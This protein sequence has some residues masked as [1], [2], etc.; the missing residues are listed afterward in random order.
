MAWPQPTDYNAAIQNLRSSVSD[1]ELRD[2]RPAL[3]ALGLPSPYAGNFA[4]VYKVHCPATG[5]TW[6]VKCFTRESP[7]LRDR[8]R[9]ISKRL[10]Q[11]RLPF[12]VDFEFVEPGFHINGASYP[13][14]KM[15]W[16]EGLALN[17]FV[18]ESLEKPKTLGHLLQLWVKLV[19]RLRKARIAH[20]DLQHGNV[21]LVPAGKGGQ[22]ALKLIDYDGMYVPALAGRRTGELGHPSYQHPQRL[23]EG[24]Y[25]AE[26]DRFS[27]LAIYS[28][29]QGLVVG[30][31]SLWKTFNNDENLLFRDTDF[32]RPAESAVFQELW[33]LSDERARTLAGRLILATQMPLDR[34]PW[35]DEVVRNGTVAPLGPQERQKV[36]GLLGNGRAASAGAARP[37]AS[38]STV[39][40]VSKP[41]PK[42]DVVPRPPDWWRRRPAEI[43]SAIAERTGLSERR[44]LGI[45][46]VAAALLILMLGLGTWLLSPSQP[47]RL[48]AQPAVYV[49]EISP[50][51]ARLGVSRSG[52]SVSGRGGRRTIT[53][54]W[55]NGES[56]IVIRGTKTDYQRFEQRLRPRPGVTE[57]LSIH[58]K[59]LAR[60]LKGHSTPVTSVAFSPDGQRIASGSDDE[61]INLWDAETGQ[62][63]RTMGGHPHYALSHC[64]CSVA[65]SPDG[66]QIASGSG[67]TIKFWDTETGQVM[68]TLNAQA[69]GEHVAFS[70]DGQ[71]IVSGSS[72]GKIRLWDA[73]TGRE[74]RTLDRFGL[75]GS[76]ALSPDGRR[77]ATGESYGMGV[78]I[79]DAETGREI[80][81]LR[82][83][84]RRVSSVAF[85]L[86]GSRIA[87]GSGDKTIKLWNAETGQL[88]RTLSGH[89]NWV[90][91]V[92][93]SPNG[94]RIASVSEDNTIR[95]WNV[96]TGQVIRTMG[97]HPADASTHWV[98]S[99]AFS[100]DGRQIAGGLGD[101]TIKIWDLE[102]SELLEETPTA[103]ETPQPSGPSPAHFLVKVSPPEATIE[104]SGDG[105]TVSGQGETRTITVEQPDGKSEIVIRATLAG[106]GPFE[107]RLWP[108]P[109]IR[110]DIP[111]RLELLPAVFHLQI[112][113]PEASLEVTGDRAT[114]AGQHEA[115]APMFGQGVGATN[116]PGAQ[117]EVGGG[118]VTVS[119]QGGTRTI[120]VDRPDGKSEIVIRVTMPDHQP[121]EKRLRTR[122]GVTEQLTI[123]LKPLV[124]TLSG[125]TSPVS[126]VAFSPDGRR[127]A[128]GSSDETI[129][130]WDAKTGRVIRTLSAHTESWV[131]SVAFSP[132]GQRIVSGSVD[133]TI[134]V[135]DAETGQLVRT[136]SGHSNGVNSVAFSPDGRQIASGSDD[137]TVK[138][139][140]AK[141]GGLV[142]GL[143]GH[144]KGVY[145][146]AFSPDG[147][148]IASGSDDETIKIW[149]AKTGRLVRTL[150]PH[151]SWVSSVAFSP[152]GQRIASGS[153][154]ETIKVW[155]TETGRLVRT[156]REPFSNVFSRQISSVAFSPDGRWIASGS[157]DCTI[158]V[159]DA[160]TGRLIR[161]LSGHTS[162]VSSVAFSPDGE[163]I[164][165]GSGDKTV[166]VWDLG[167]GP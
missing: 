139:W 109:G 7:A 40:D 55:A 66:R 117:L 129:K 155:N 147:R 162:Y 27:H 116:R 163:R 120:T 102:V 143:R 29:V 17:Q 42:A 167:T 69:D 114:A 164:A 105:A 159:W 34:V 31:P 59:R 145:S 134:K 115:R 104:V 26:V 22:L 153:S 136:L 54:H 45:G 75:L 76:V 63:I 81:T 146:V 161:T 128:S 50:P 2:G 23:R 90:T 101:G 64:V 87:S 130:V 48:P 113:P 156:L 72:G 12:M 86:D 92:A 16:V 93:F 140:N 49:V 68:R 97:G 119:G 124:M 13:F 19:G 154:A 100:P 98:Y 39:P 79:W 106:Y 6:A 3:N 141:T 151:K 160:E 9:A 60:T 150:G 51:D 95:L 43:L 91:S 158:K 71:R 36:D 21:L 137:K 152:D 144:T 14:L 52:V 15:R 166:K 65:F 56:E 83:H 132:D 96:E 122:P 125:H 28:A 24:I 30:G 67:S 74:L 11:A 112:S 88:I 131:D 110:L 111:V 89:T 85:S 108:R 107:R 53:V 18:G 78:R 70:L 5:N 46:G 82:G 35:L 62:V 32:E 47:A 33:G 157:R 73:K 25:S 58:L 77:I 99:V 44:V 126:S 103:K 148:R 57:Q 138:I 84:A 10:H 133:E 20:A 121:F 37:A 149:N 165:T 61:T 135:W 38:P 4:D 8:Y 127:I 80:R 41:E 142:R 94:R 118:K 123:H 1:E